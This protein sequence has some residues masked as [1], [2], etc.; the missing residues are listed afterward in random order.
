MPATH[1]LTIAVTGASGYLAGR[2]IEHLEADDRIG[3]VLGFDLREPDSAPSKLVFDQFDIRNEYLSQRLTGVDVVVHLAF[4]M[5]PIKD[6]AHMRDVN[7]AGSQNVFRCAAEAGVKKIV[8]P[9]SAT[10]YGAHPDNDFPLTEDSPLRANLDFSYPAHKLEVEY[11]IKEFRQEFPD[12]TMT[13]FRPAIVF[14][15]HVDNAWSHALELPVAF[16]VRDHDPPLQFVHEDDVARALHHAVIEDLD[17]P[18]NLAPADHV[19]VDEMLRI[20]GRRRI[21][22]TEPNAFDIARK[23]WA[24]GLGEAP[25]GMLHY[26]MHPWVVSPARLE[27]TG[28]RCERSSADAFVETAARAKGFVRIGRS[29]VNKD[30]ARRGAL[31]GLLLGGAAAG[32][33]MARS[34]GD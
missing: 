7:V 20:L 31:A 16:G 33:K 14:G 26:L 17:G 11:V 6:E 29:R 30:A 12:I 28:F 15:S 21:N 32:L 25:A 3:H 5:D 4:V 1:K 19:E 34:R 22:L 18:F 10:V 24:L 2:L 13:I 27:S 23:L 9:S 8:Y